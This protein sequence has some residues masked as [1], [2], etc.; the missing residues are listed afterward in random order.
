MQI[1]V[2][3]FAVIILAGG[4]LLSLP[5]SSRDGQGIPFIN[6]L[7]TAASATCV[8]GLVV[9][10]TYSQFS[11]FGQIVILLLIQVGGLGFMFVAILFSL[12]AGRKIG[13]RERSLLMDSLSALKLGGV[14]R[15]T[16]KAL[17]MTFSLELV[18]A[19]IL[20]SRFVP[21]F[22]FLPGVWC[23]IFHSV[24]SFCNAGFDILGRIAPYT[25]LTTFYD[26]P[27]VIVTIAVLIVVGG[28]GF[29]VWDDV[30]Q[31]KLHFA[32]YNLHAKLM[33]TATLIL[34]VAGAVLFF[35][36]E[37][38]Y[39]MKGMEL[40]GRLLSSFFAAVT[41]RTAGFNTVDV[42][43]M[44]PGGTL[45]TM[46]LMLVG[47]GPGSTGGGMKVTTV[48]II[49]IGIAARVRDRDDLSVFSRRLESGALERA[50]TSA[51]A[52]L[53]LAAAGSL[54]LCAQ[55]FGVTDALFEVLSGLGTVGLSR[56][57]TPALP[58]VSRLTIML[59]MYAGRVGSLAVVMSMSIRREKVGRHL[60]HVS[61]KVIIG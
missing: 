61:E 51:G 14:V 60:R 38:G 46:V 16:K 53:M 40:G 23:G 10:D 36:M 35:F 20:A 34:I 11:L 12:F 28:L 47:A 57:I 55:G 2:I 45:L 4:L 24:S 1:L 50:A 13:L 42:A 54:I 21:E 15:L 48:V 41:P 8:T 19:V 58:V 33:I 56:G 26:D 52:Y 31:K 49:L 6:G 27:F 30:S 22:G 17:I 37:A 5:S 3:G 9:Y 29:F 59:L 32:K 44:S 39:S 18:G 7:F 43:E 25:S